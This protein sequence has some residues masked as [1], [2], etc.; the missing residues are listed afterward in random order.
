MSQV[1]AQTT[2]CEEY[3]EVELQNPQTAASRAPSHEQTTERARKGKKKEVKDIEERKKN[4]EKRQD[5]KN[6][7]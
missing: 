4:T 1:P 2:T 7:E 3:A 6:T 5:Y